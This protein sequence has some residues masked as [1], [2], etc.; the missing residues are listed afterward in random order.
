[1]NFFGAFTFGVKTFLPGF[2]WLAILI[3]GEDKIGPNLAL[4]SI[5]KFAIAQPTLA[6]GLALPVATLLGLL[7]NIVVFMGPLDSLVRDPVLEQDE[8][9]RELC[10]HL[11]G[12][13]LDRCWSSGSFQRPDLRE[14]FDSK[15]DPELLLIEKIGVATVDHIREGYWYHLEFQ[16]NL[17][18]S[19]V[20]VMIVTLF[21][22]VE[23]PAPTTSLLIL[24]MTPLVGVY[25]LKS[26]RKNFA[27]Y[28]AKRAS[29]IAAVLSSDKMK[30]VAGKR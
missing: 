13:L 7:S 25:L 10:A 14:E 23:S 29:L 15:I 4:S 21:Y 30:A 24:L 5:W 9:L 19:L 2:V 27:R 28:M 18:L 22:V 3:V 8:K 20:G 26:A 1:M 16:L 17:L 6:L 12:C 11:S